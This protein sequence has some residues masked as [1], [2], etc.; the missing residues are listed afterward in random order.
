MHFFFKL[1]LYPWCFLFVFFT[2]DYLF[3]TIFRYCYI[4]FL[5]PPLVRNMGYCWFLTIINSIVI[6]I[7]E[8]GYFYPSNYFLRKKTRGNTCLKGYFWDSLS[9]GLNY[10]LEGWR[11][12]TLSSFWEIL[13]IIFSPTLGITIK[14]PKS[15]NTESNLKFCISLVINGV[16]HFLSCIFFTTRLSFY[17]LR[18]D[19]FFLK[20][21]LQ[22]P[23][24]Y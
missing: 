8:H 23:N 3:L 20:K 4:S 16:K 12:F 2:W 19:D 10:I 7:L 21:P 1:G 15:L 5:A 24:I 13:M 17:E 18:G 6:N 11:Q 14:P 9:L 22:R